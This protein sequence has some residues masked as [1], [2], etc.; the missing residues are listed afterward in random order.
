[1]QFK[2]YVRVIEAMFTYVADIRLI[3]IRPWFEWVKTNLCE[4][5]RKKKEEKN[6]KTAHKSNF[7][8]IL[9]VLFVYLIFFSFSVFASTIIAIMK[10]QN[11][12]RTIVK[13]EKK[14]TY[15]LKNWKELYMKNVARFCSCFCFFCWNSHFNWRYC[16]CSLMLFIQ[17]V[18][19]FFV[20]L[21]FKLYFKLKIMFSCN[22]HK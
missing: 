12:H 22:S 13:S 6:N 16:Y 18:S 9:P 5:Q 2:C 15:T 19:L 8:L 20:S 14:F 21:F 7:N 17:F 11:T 1:M 3:R 10:Q 4:C